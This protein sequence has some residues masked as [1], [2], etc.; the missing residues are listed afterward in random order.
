MKPIRRSWSNDDGIALV[1]AMFMV[2]VLSMLGAS[3]VGVGRS[4]TLSSL[5]YKTLSQARYAAESGLNSATNYLL[6][7]YTAPGNDAADPIGVFVYQNTSPVTYNGAPVV[8]SSDAN[9]S[10]YP[11][12]AKKNAFAACGQ[13]RAHDGDE[14]GRV[15]R[16]GQAALDEALHGRHHAGGCH[17]PD[18]GDHRHRYARRRRRRQRGGHR[19][20]REAGRTDVPLCGVCDRQGLRGPDIRR[21]RH[22]RQLRLRRPRGSASDGRQR[23]QR[24]HQRRPRRGWCQHHHQRHAVNAAVRSRQLHREQRDRA[25]HRRQQQCGGHRRSRRSSAER[26]VSGSPVRST[27]RRGPR[28]RP[29]Q[30]TAAAP[31]VSPRA[32]CSRTPGART[33]A[34]D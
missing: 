8:L 33:S 26:Q 19:H 27:P 10:N 31:L 12:A 29:F 14:Q 11:I 2:L 24:R 3:L 4:E 7:T 1:L 17:H 22:D 23:R 20:H 28:T 6:F 32:R 16:D 18:V 25:G 34:S 5:N 13:G 15:H 21:R 9:E 30:R